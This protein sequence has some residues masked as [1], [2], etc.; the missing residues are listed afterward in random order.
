MYA[1]CMW[2]SNCVHY[3]VSWLELQSDVQ[4]GEVTELHAAV[5]FYSLFICHHDW[6]HEKET[7]NAS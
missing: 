1:L 6:T 5:S 3:S 7:A 4:S 2:L